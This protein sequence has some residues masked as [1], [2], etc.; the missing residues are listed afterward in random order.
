MDLEQSYILF[1]V[2]SPIDF[3]KRF[4]P[5]VVEIQTGVS[6][7]SEQSITPPYSTTGPGTGEILAAIQD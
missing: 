6:R 2:L 5:L 1:I 4:C 7:S 3:I